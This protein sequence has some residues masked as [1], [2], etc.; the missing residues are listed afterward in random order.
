[1]IACTAA[2]S[3]MASEL[4]KP[5]E[6]S[7]EDEAVG[8]D[9]KIVG[10]GDDIAGHEGEEVALPRAHK[11]VRAGGDELAGDDEKCVGGIEGELV[12]ALLNGLTEHGWHVGFDHVAVLGLYD[13]E[14]TLVG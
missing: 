6:P 2:I 13:P 12:A 9:L 10:A 8:G 5:Q 1:M 3:E 7:A 11:F 14:A 4:R